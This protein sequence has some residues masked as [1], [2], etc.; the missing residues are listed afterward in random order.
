MSTTTLGLPLMFEGQTG[1]EIQYNE[2]IV[3]VSALLRT[4][5]KDILNTPPGSPAQED[6]YLIGPAPTGDWVGKA[7]YIATYIGTAWK[8]ISPLEGWSL[9]IDEEDERYTYDGTSW[10]V[11]GVKKESVSVTG[12]VSK[13]AGKH[14]VNLTDTL[15]LTVPDPTTYNANEQQRTELILRVPGAH[16]VTLATPSGV[17]RSDLA[18]SG[19]SSPTLSGQYVQ[20]SL[21][22]DGTDWITYANGGIA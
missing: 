14:V 15:T 13:F 1:N 2:M 17:F 3:W 12:V 22:T 8:T 19:V 7:Y 11:Y 20:L 21:H 4:G 10:V 9:W 6:T 5:A 18:P 16:T